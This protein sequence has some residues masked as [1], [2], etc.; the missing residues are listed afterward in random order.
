MKKPDFISFGWI[1]PNGSLEIV[2]SGRI[3]SPTEFEIKG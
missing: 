3:F 2:A 1:V